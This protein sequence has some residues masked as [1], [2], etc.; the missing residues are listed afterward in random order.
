M[1]KTYYFQ[2]DFDP[3]S[4]P[5]IAY[6]IGRH[7]ATGYGLW[8][9]IVELLHSTPN[10]RLPIKNYLLHSLSATLNLDFGFVNAF[11]NDCI[12][13]AELLQSDGE[14]IWSQRVFDNI[15]NMES[16][17][18]R[19]AKAGKV[20]AEKRKQKSNDVEHTLNDVEH[21]L[22]DVE[23]TLSDVQQKKRKE[24]K[25]YIYPD[26]DEVIAF[27]IE[28]GYKKEAAIKAFEYYNEAQWKD[29]DGNKVKNWKQKMRGVWFREENKASTIIQSGV[30]YSIPVN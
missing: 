21:M 16:R 2:H 26:Q 13:E 28:N 5:K 17:R 9:R 30:H 14:C 19:Y 8:W 12:N 18:E 1:K 25:V 29:R 7:G 11:I 6:I 3:T 22:N 4:D 20:S 10:N 15:G 24:K 23:Q 27:F